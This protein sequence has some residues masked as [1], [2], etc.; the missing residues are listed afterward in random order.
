MYFHK[1]KTQ[2]VLCLFRHSTNYYFN[3]ILGATTADY[4]ISS[5]PCLQYTDSVVGHILEKYDNI[6]E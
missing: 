5:L 4:N 1:C 2:G 3:K 6:P